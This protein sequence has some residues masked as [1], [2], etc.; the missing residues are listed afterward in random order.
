MPNLAD[1]G[2]LFEEKRIT[3]SSAVWEK[4]SRWIHFRGPDNERS[5]LNE[6][7]S[8]ISCFVFRF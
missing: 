8:S 4:G 5:E 3:Y 1:K 7:L 6:V 2:I